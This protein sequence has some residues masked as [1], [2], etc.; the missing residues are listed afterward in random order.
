MEGFTR[1]AYGNGRFVAIGFGVAT[2]T[3][4]IDW[5]VHQSQ[6]GGNDIT[7]G[8]GQ[9]VVVAGLLD[10]PRTIHTSADGICWVQRQPGI[11]WATAQL[12]GITY[13]NGH[14]VVCGSGRMIL[15]S[16]SILDL[17]ITRST[18]TGP[19]T[20]ALEGSTGLDYTIQSST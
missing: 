19:L 18:G 16:G 4:G 10:G 5:V 3:D 9:F 11:N 1:I 8:A 17:S 15:Q 12:N 14:F 6:I 7:Y 2:S 20:L 13:G